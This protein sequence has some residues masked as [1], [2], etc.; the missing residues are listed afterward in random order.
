MTSKNKSHRNITIKKREHYVSK[1][2]WIILSIRGEPYDRGYSHGSRLAS[3]FKQV[4]KV[5][6]YIV[7]DHFHATFDEYLET[8]SRLI[9]PV[10]MNS[11]PEFYEEIRGI[12]E[13]IMSKQSAIP[14]NVH[15]LIAWNAVLSMYSYYGNNHVQ[16]CC[17]FIATG[18]ATSDGKIVM[19]HNT[20]SDYASAVLGNIVLHVHPTKGRAFRMQTYPGYIASGTD[21]FLCSSGIIGCETTISKTNYKP[22]FGAPY[23]C[24]IRQVMQYANNLADCASIMQTDNAGDY[25]CSWLFGDINTNNIML[26]EIGYNRVHIEETNNGVYY[27][28]NSAIDYEL[29]S[30]DTTD[31]FDDLNTS[32]GART[33][34]LQSLLL[35]EYAGKI[36]I[37]NAKTILSDHYDVYSNKTDPG[38]RTICKHNKSSPRGATDGKVVDTT[39]AKTLSFY[40]RMGPTCGKSFRVKEFVK[41]HPKYKKWANVLQDMP[42]RKWAKI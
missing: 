4:D 30:I 22:Q 21:W 25:A 7:V 31:S 2:G 24:R 3:H 11:Y 26:C 40:G 13:G 36:S 37:A 20:H 28:A 23:F 15:Y 17:A 6:K 5:F 12:S 27:G 42:T 39:M 9:S 10:V 14:V 32:T 29:R 18:D 33:M 19:A 41:K 16:R 8:C 34:R 1:N 38:E 35:R